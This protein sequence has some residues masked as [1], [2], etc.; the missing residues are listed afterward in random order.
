MHFVCEIVI[1]V[2]SQWPI[3]IK[4]HAYAA[5]LP[6]QQMDNTYINSVTIHEV[7]V[8]S[9]PLPLLLYMLYAK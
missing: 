8:I 2:P 7:I 5:L 6:W 3:V 9:V 4:M 1:E